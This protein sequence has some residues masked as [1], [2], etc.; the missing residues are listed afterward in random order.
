MSLERRIYKHAFLLKIKVNSNN[1]NLT[2]ANVLETKRVKHAVSKADD[3][4]GNSLLSDDNIDFGFEFSEYLLT[5]I[6][7]N[8]PQFVTTTSS[9]S[10]EQKPFIFFTF[11]K[12]N[13]NATS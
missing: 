3:I 8:I 7:V 9:R 11:V 12:G 2:E 5:R 4:I 13:N 6:F 10:S 1:S